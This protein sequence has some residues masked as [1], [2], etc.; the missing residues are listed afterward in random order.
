MPYSMVIKH[1]FPMQ[2]GEV[3]DTCS[4]TEN[5]YKWINFKPEINIEEGVKKFVQW[6][7]TF[8]S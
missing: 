7:N 1:H 2:S 4:N 8:Y 5:L 6:H 3:I